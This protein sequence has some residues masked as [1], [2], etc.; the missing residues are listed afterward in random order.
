MKLINMAPSSRLVR[1]PRF[2]CGNSGSNPDGVTSEL[3]KL[4]TGI[5]RFPGVTYLQFSAEQSENKVCNHNYMRAVSSVVEHR[6][7]VTRVIGSIPIPPTRSFIKRF[8]VKFNS[9]PRRKAGEP[10]E[11]LAW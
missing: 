6:L 1:T 2:Q 10:T 4:V 5:K 9:Q 3:V 8:S 7:D 11:T